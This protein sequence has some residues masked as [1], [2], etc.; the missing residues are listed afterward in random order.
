MQ[1]P[2]NPTRPS[3]HAKKRF[4][5]K[6]KSLKHTRSVSPENLEVCIRASGIALILRFAYED[7][8]PFFV[9]LS[10]WLLSLVN[11]EEGRPPATD[12]DMQLFDAVERLDIDRAVGLVAQG[13]NINALD[14]EG[15]TPLT[16][17]TGA[18]KF[19][20][21]PCDEADEARESQP[22]LPQ[23]E[24]IEM[25][26][27]LLAL[28]AD[29]NLFGYEGFYSLTKAVLRHEDE[30]VLFLLKE[31]ADPNHSHF[32][33]EDPDEVSTPVYYAD[34]DFCLVVE[35]SEDEKRLQRI[36][37]ALKNAGAA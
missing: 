24:R 1:C 23:E 33:D 31:G 19:D 35:G 32:R 20:F 14:D 10:P 7:I 30:V 3:G 13:A 5:M 22:D 11:A 12:L 16:K 21:L 36:Y 34:G 9:S 27:R 18:S 2:R 26:R 15:E 17:L 29:I 4:L 37:D 25:M 6:Y 8:A 28:G